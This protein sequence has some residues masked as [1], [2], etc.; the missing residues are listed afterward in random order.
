MLTKTLFN[1]FIECPVWLWLQKWRPDL[2]PEETLELKQRFAMGHEIDLIARQLFPGGVEVE[3]FNAKGAANTKKAMA[4]KA[5]VLYQPTAVFKR[6][7]TCRADIMVRSGQVWDLYEVKMGTEVKPENLYD[8]AFQR[9]CFEKAGVSIGKTCLVHV[10]RDFVRHGEVLAKDLLV[11]EDITDDVDGL[12]EETEKL[13]KAAQKVLKI[14]AAPDAG[15]IA[16]C[17][18]P[19]RCEYLSLYREAFPD[20]AWLAMKAAE[21]FCEINKPAIRKMLETL[22]YPLYFLDYE[23]FGPAIPPFDGY[24]PYQNIPFQYSLHVQRKPGAAL[25]HYEFLARDFSDPVPDLLSE[26]K[27]VIGPKGSVIVWYATFETGRNSEMAELCPDYADFLAGV[28]D[29]VFDLLEIFR[30]KSALYANSEFGGSASLKSVLPVLCPELAYDS[31]DIQEGGTAS[32]SWPLL[33]DPDAS[34]AE[35]KRLA[36]A[37]LEYCERDT[38]AM[39][40]IMRRVCQDVGIKPLV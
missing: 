18:N 13:I 40:G 20:A 33:C 25:E 28:N 38:M 29:R 2:L 26:M 16:M 19:E 11:I 23:T 35:K 22:E 21:P 24:R 7:L 1:H 8:V 31:L 9:L 15:L 6:E 10:N 17:E 12:L 37:M 14:E 34:A 27:K 32:A 39:V 3:G 36:Q 5:R 30:I 4:G